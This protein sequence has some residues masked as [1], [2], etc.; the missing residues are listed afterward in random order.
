MWKKISLIT[1]ALI[2]AGCGAKQTAVV[3]EDLPAASY[4]KEL[5]AYEQAQ[6]NKK[7]TASLWADVGSHGTV[8]LDYKA[9]QIGDLIT[10]RIEE[11]A[12][13]NNSNSTDTQRS[14]SYNMEVENMFGLPNNMGIDNFLGS[15]RP[16]DPTLALTAGSS[17]AGSG[18][19]G[20]SD[21]VNA[22]IAARVVEVL[23][24]GNMIIEGQR[25]IVVDDEKQTITIRGI[26]RQ[27]D[28]DAANTVSSTAIADA[29]I[30]YYGDGVIS[31][32]NRKGWLAR[33]FDWISP[34]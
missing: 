19:K 10:V 17:F 1:L 32:A 34:F 12:N 15:G 21:R 25:E 18:T 29:Q 24:S 20:R 28:V 2:V 30:R 11:K 22:T 7:P 6:R 31:D 14:T 5:E 9:R 8:F 3:S 23:P 26:V 33:F 27:K 4:K 16:F 13:A